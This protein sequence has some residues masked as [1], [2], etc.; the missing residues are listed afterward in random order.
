MEVFNVEMMIISCFIILVAIIF[1]LLAMILAL[2]HDLRQDNERLEALLKKMSI[3]D[4]IFDA[5][6]MELM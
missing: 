6:E 5:R 2:N 1:I 3:F 4:N